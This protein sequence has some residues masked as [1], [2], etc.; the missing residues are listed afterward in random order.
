MSAPECIK[1]I[2]KGMWALL[3]REV[4]IKVQAIFSQSKNL[5]ANV[6]LTIFAVLTQSF[7]C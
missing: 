2:N 6:L 4:N 3:S 7:C 5:T 1:R